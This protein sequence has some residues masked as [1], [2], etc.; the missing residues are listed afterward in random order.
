MFTKSNGLA[1]N[2]VRNFKN[3]LKKIVSEETDIGAAMNR[4]LLT[5]RTTLHFTTGKTPAELMFDGKNELDLT[6]FCHLKRTTY[7]IYSYTI[8]DPEQ[9]SQQYG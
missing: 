5:Y 1:K 2:G 9:L 6:T 3:G 4:Y 7:N 8:N